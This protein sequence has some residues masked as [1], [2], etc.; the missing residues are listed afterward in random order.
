MEDKTSHINEDALGNPINRVIFQKNNKT[1]HVIFRYLWQ[2]L[3]LVSTCKKG[4]SHSIR[5]LALA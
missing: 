5:Y 3:T 4:I 1:E 2:T